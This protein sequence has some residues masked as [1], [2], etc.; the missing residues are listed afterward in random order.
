M[1]NPRPPVPP[2]EG[3]YAILRNGEVHGP[4]RPK[5]CS[6]PIPPPWYASEYFIGLVWTEKGRGAIQWDYRDR[7]VIT[8]HPKE[9]FDIIA[10][11]SPEVMQAIVSGQFER[12]QEAVILARD[13][14]SHYGDLHAAKPDDHKATA[15]YKLAAKMN[16]AIE[17]LTSSV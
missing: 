13:T 7:G 2:V 16:A 9:E 12:L 14:F 1:T 10:T 11:I 4:M 8:T 15:N 6:S 5:T 17:N 3:H